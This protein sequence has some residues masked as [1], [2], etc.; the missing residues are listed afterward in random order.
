MVRMAA[1]LT[2]K[3]KSLD[4]GLGAL[5]VVAFSQKATFSSQRQRGV[6]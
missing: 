3:L 4:G 6:Q 1:L 2:F 5:A